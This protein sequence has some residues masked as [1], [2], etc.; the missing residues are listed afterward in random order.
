[1]PETERKKNTGSLWILGIFLV[2]A[3]CAVLVITSGVSVYSR[4]GEKNDAAYDRRTVSRY[5]AVKVNSA[6]SYEDV[7]VV[8]VGP[9]ET[10][11]CIS[12]ELSGSVYDT[13]VYAFDGWLC[14]LFVPEGTKPE[15]AGGEK[16]IRCESLSLEENDGLVTAMVKL[17]GCDAFPLFFCCGEEA[18]R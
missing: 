5:L 17:P 8:P 1:M 3:V 15:P 12:E 16:V 14:E 6:G 2:F 4:L 11:L 13:L 18:A 9:D 7:S 10:A